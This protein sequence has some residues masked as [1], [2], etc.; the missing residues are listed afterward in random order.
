MSGNKSLDPR[1]RAWVEIQL[2]CLNS[3]P[4]GKPDKKDTNLVRNC[5][6]TVVED[7]RF[8]NFIMYCIIGN[9]VV[10]S[11]FWY[12]QPK[13]LE[14]P[15]EIINLAFVIIFTLEAMIKITAMCGLYFKDSWNIFDF[16][17]V[18]STVIAL[19]LKRVLN[20]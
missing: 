16:F 6:I 19:L 8:D 7:K 1:Q 10:L 14:K 15:L 11:L 20:I 9:A 12:M 13:T 18:V 4:K 5:C 2:M 17:I 3:R